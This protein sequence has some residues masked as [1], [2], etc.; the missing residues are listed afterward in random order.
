VKVSDNTRKISVNKTEKYPP[1]KKGANYT[2]RITSIVE[3]L[4][5][6]VI[7]LPIII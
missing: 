5:A 1:V 3:F 4:S 7:R 2:G 6:Y